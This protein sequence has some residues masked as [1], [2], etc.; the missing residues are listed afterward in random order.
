MIDNYY[1]LSDIWGYLRF[2]QNNDKLEIADCIEYVKNKCKHCYVNDI[3]CNNCEYHKLMKNHLKSRAFAR[4]VYKNL[5]E[6]GNCYI[7][8]AT[9]LTEE[10]IFDLKVF[11]FIVKT[12]PAVL[13]GGTIIEV[14]RRI[15]NGK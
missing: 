11:G 9:P 1:E 14:V 10:Q 15:E 7:K 13:S 8:Q 6:L 5:N 3:K 12:K 2:T 4:Y